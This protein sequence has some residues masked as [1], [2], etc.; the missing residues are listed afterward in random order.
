MKKILYLYFK[1]LVSFAN[2]CILF[3][4]SE[5]INQESTGILVIPKGAT[6]E[7]KVKNP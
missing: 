7:K 2:L 3:Y 5:D 1:K 6:A 4:A